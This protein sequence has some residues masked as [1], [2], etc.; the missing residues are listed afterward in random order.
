MILPQ[1]SENV[2]REQLF[3]QSV[4]NMSKIMKFIK[5]S[6]LNIKGISMNEDMNATSNI[7]EQ[8]LK[9]YLI[10]RCDDIS[11]DSLTTNLN[12]LLTCTNLN[13]KPLFYH[14]LTQSLLCLSVFSS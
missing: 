9:E 3:Y 4:K 11:E 6:I 7:G 10:H 8:F 13:L 1:N 5:G 14:Y 12:Q 2:L